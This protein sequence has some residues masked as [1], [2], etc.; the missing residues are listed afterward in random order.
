MR[1]ELANLKKSILYKDELLSKYA[2]EKHLSYLAHERAKQ[3]QKKLSLVEINS[4]KLLKQQK[5]QYKALN[6]LKKLESENQSLKKVRCNLLD[7]LRSKNSQIESYA[8]RLRSAQ[9]TLKSSP[10]FKS[11][12]T[13]ASQ[14]SF[15]S[16]FSPTRK[17]TSNLNFF[18]DL[19]SNGSQASNRSETR[20][21]FQLQKMLQDRDVKI[22]RNS[23]EMLDLKE[24]H[25]S[26]VG[27]LNR[28]HRASQNRSMCLL[29]K[30]KCEI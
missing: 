26:K 18:G 30:R 17:S 27:A 29:E 5:L 25:F 24:K 10:S 4:K 23:K 22:E 6:T 9:H 14:K 21:V 13:P 7:E 20:S 15:S 8:T 16:F 28:S 2:K 19:R 12:L 3:A 1:S 11:K